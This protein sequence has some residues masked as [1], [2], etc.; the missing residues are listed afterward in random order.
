[1]KYPW[2]ARQHRH[3]GRDR[4]SRCYLR[5]TTALGLLNTVL[6][7]V[8]NRVLVRCVDSETGR[9]VQWRWDRAT[10]HPPAEG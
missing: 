10:S 3:R 8:I 5:G 6:G 4:C 7:C 2:G 1:M 9:T